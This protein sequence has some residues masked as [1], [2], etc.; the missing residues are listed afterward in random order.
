M[1]DNTIHIL[2]A[3]NFG[4]KMTPYTLSLYQANKKGTMLKYLG[5]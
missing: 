1:M 3:T 4:S 2:F 5:N